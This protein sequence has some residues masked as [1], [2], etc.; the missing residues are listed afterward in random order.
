M[1]A[2]KKIIA[3]VRVIDINFPW[4]LIRD[5]QNYKL[6]DNELTHRVVNDENTVNTL[7]LGHGVY[8]CEDVG[9]EINSGIYAETKEDVQI[10]AARSIA[11]V[12]DKLGLPYDRTA[13]TQAPSFTKNFL[14]N[15]PHKIVQAIAKAREINKAHTTF[16]DTILKYSHK[17]RIH[18]EINQLRGDSGGTVTGRFSMN[19]PNLQQIPARN[20]DL[21]P[22]RR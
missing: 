20:K 6:N 15:H 18:A 14:A 17:G 2:Q 21:G 7:Q 4:S 9:A 12:F 19:N 10:W 22:P 13:K 3:I 1:T 5:I 11:K 8:S 16:I